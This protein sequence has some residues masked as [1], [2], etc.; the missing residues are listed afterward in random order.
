MF[1]KTSKAAQFNIFTSP[2]T[3]SSGNALKF[4]ED[5]A[6]WHNLFR[7][8]VTMRI[9]ENSFSPLYCANNGT[10]NSPVHVLVAMMII[11]EAEVISDQ[12]HFENCRYNMLTL[13]SIEL[14]NVDDSIPTEST[15][16]LFCKRVNDYTKAE[17]EN[18]FAVLFAEISQNQCI[19]FN[20]SRKRIRMDSKLLDSNIAKYLPW[21]KNIQFSRG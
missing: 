1:R 19:D 11:K 6:A 4:Y 5:K 3:L 21:S 14:L 17:N 18:L 12:K 2:G 10:L 20:V 16:Y 8:Q 15:Y 7:Q 13:R 9:N